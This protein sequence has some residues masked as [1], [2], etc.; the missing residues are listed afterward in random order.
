MF[1]IQRLFPSVKDFFS[2]LQIPEFLDRAITSIKVPESTVGRCV[3]CFSSELLS[4]FIVATNFRALAKGYI[5]WTVI[6]DGLIVLQ[7]TIVSKIFIENEKTRNGLSTLSFT[8]GGM[9]GSAL[10][11][12]MTRFIWG[13]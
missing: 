8:L 13:S 4:F 6:T 11:I 2:N 5:G 3:F 9:C 12:L 10:S 1:L 7:S